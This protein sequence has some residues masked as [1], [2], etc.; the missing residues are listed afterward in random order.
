MDKKFKIQG[1]EVSWYNLTDSEMLMLYKSDATSEEDKD[2]LKQRIIDRYERVC[3]P[4]EGETNDELFAR[5][6]G[7]FVNGKMCSKRKVA[8]Q[9]CREHRYLQ[10]EMFKVC[11]EYIKLLAENYEKGYYDPRNEWACKTSKFIIDFYHR[12]LQE[13]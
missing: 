9:M 4:S 1:R 8:E 13:L 10:N 2:F 6:F 3:C 12:F 7:D 5:N 11:F